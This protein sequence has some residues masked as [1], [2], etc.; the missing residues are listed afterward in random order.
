MRCVAD[1]PDAGVDAGE[2]DAGGSDT[3]AVDTGTPDAFAV[4][5]A[6]IDA[7]APPDAWA[8]DACSA[9]AYY[10]DTDSDGFGNPASSIS[11]CV[12][13]SGYVAN[14]MDC[15][16]SSPTIRPGA[17]EV[18][19]EIDDN[20][21]GGVDEGVQMTLY[22]DDDADGFGGTMTGLACAP[23]AG[24]VATNTDCNDSDA[25][26]NPSR[27][28]TCNGVDDNCVGGIDD[29]NPGGGMACASGLLG[30]CAAGTTVCRTGAV[31]CNPN[32]MP[33][34]ETCNLVDDDCNGVV[35]NGVET[36]F[37]RDADRDTYGSSTIVRACTL[38]DMAATR[39][40]DCN[41][42]NA[43][44]YPT[45]L[46]TCDGVDNDCDTV[47]DG[48]SATLWCGQMAQLASL[49]AV[50]AVCGSGT[51]QATSCAAMR[52]NCDSMGGC[53]TDTSSSATNCRDC[54]TVCAW[55]RCNSS[56]C[57]DAVQIS[58][59]GT[60]TCALRRDGTVVCWGRN[61]NGE[62]GNGTTMNSTTPVVVSGLTGIQSISAGDTHTCALAASG[63][64]SCW[65]AGTLGQL[66]NGSATDR[67]TPVS[68]TGLPASVRQISAGALHTCAV[69]ATGATYCWGYNFFGQL[70]DGTT[71]NRLIPTLIAGSNSAVVSAGTTHTCALA[72]G[73]NLLFCWGN[74][75]YGQLGD[76]TTTNR[77][78]PTYSSAF[79]AVQ[80]VSSG[81]AYTCV[82]N[83]T[84]GVRCVGLNSGGQLGNGTT[85]NSATPVTVVGLSAV[86]QIETGL[87]TTYARLM[88][89]TMRAWGANPLGQFGDGTTTSRLTP[90][91]VP[92]SAVELAAGQ[93]HACSRASTGVIRC[94]GVNGGGQLGNGSTTNSST[95]VIVTAP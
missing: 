69:L 66:G 90:T 11:G 31:A 21:A 68:V 36:M 47:S 30:A 70:G 49:S 83:T 89:G 95:P 81:A 12:M 41:D 35:D 7:F 2:V 18:C 71:T 3:G 76:G 24:L 91:I 33:I 78:A 65:G 50:S 85:T 74:N 13:P 58:A 93:S 38:P 62:L 16:D 86:A 8:P 42:A 82:V 92:G 53:E 4:P 52:G 43:A 87:E 75:F 10:A 28:E 19:N 25:N 17:T 6:A 26:I 22:R 34:A 23:R 37:Y 48:P 40:G 73:S 61:T 46:E 94:W 79:G 5:D 88:D 63:V 45:A 15:D 44:I 67:T 84:G 32:S 77:S 9:T 1:Q 27:T 57:N 59:G 64:V 55:N 39:S 80:S 20:C 29:S 54:G 60:H 51:C 56:V 72:A 14:N